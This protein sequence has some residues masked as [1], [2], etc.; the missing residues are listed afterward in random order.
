MKKMSFEPDP[1]EVLVKKGPANFKKGFEAIGGRLYLTDRRLVFRSHAANAQHIDAE[2][3][4]SSISD[5]IPRWTRFLG[6]PLV[7]NTL[8]VITRTN[9]SFKFVVSGRASWAIIIG[10]TINSSG[11]ENGE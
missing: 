1:D 6:L 11:A 4:V 8:E 3:E 7:P 5:L 10:K 2:I 9:E